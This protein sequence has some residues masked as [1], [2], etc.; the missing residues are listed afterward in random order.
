MVNVKIL[1]TVDPINS[2]KSDKLIVGPSSTDI[3][4]SHN[5][6][7]FKIYENLAHPF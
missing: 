7:L 6:N 1:L 4:N 2:M 3:V 5:I